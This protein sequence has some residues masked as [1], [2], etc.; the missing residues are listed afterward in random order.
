MRMNL[1]M[2]TKDPQEG[3]KQRLRREGRQWAKTGK[4]WETAAVTMNSPCPVSLWE[5]RPSEQAARALTFVTVKLS[6]YRACRLSEQQAWHHATQP[7]WGQPRSPAGCS[8]QGMASW[9]ASAMAEPVG[10]SGS[11]DAGIS[12]MEGHLARNADQT[13]KVLKWQCSFI[14]HTF[15]ECLL[16]ASLCQGHEQSPREVFAFCSGLYYA[17]P[18]NRDRLWYL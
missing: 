17:S 2:V 14:G 18:S 9:V 6:R 13:G 11:G 16:G 15:N 10:S 5:G 7:V 3:K 12:G 4:G 1:M 8:F